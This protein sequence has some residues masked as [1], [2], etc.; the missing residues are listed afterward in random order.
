M[1][2]REILEQLREPWWRGVLVGFVL[3]LAFLAT[4]VWQLI[5]IAA[6]V[7][8]F[9]AGRGRSGAIRGIQAVGP[10]WFLWLLVLSALTPVEEVVVL[11]GS[12]LGAG[13]GLVVFLFALIPI[14][15]VVTVILGL[16]GG[17]VGVALRYASR[18]RS[19][20]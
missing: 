5:V 9:L 19:T 12:I 15:L 11:L 20:R 17:L 2:A 18:M 6:A 7:T 3:T 1:R 13:W 10:A 16:A 8:G 4:T 14:V